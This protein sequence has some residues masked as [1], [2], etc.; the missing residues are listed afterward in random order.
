MD[1][2]HIGRRREKRKRN[3]KDRKSPETSE[4]VLGG[5]KGRRGNIIG[6]QSKDIPNKHQDAIG[7][8]ER[9]WWTD[10]REVWDETTP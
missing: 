1:T 10:L 6:E 4:L 7:K 8:M 2:T 3:E 5:E 9:R